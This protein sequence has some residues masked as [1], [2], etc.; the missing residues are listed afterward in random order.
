MVNYYSG[1]MAFTGGY[2]LAEVI[3]CVVEI[4]FGVRYLPGRSAA[5]QKSGKIAGYVLAANILSFG[6]G[7]WLAHVIPGIF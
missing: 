3:V 6:V 1:P 5:A 7:L 2:I 4:F